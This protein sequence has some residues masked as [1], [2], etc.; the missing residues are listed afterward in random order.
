MTIV[1]FAEIASVLHQ[2]CNFSGEHIYTKTFSDDAYFVLYEQAA[3]LENLYLSNHYEGKLI[4]GYIFLQQLEVKNNIVAYDEDHSPF[5]LAMGNVKASHLVLAGNPFYINENL[6]CNALW[7]IYNHGAL[8]VKGSVTTQILYSDGFPFEFGQVAAIGIILGDERA[9][10]YHATGS[11]MVLLTKTHTPEQ[12]FNEAGQALC[13]QGLFLYLSA[14]TENKQP[15]FQTSINFYPSF[16][17]NLRPVFNEI[18]SNPVFKKQ[19]SVEIIS[20]H[21]EQFETVFSYVT[22]ENMDIILAA[23]THQKY[24]ASIL[25]EKNTNTVYLRLAMYT[26]SSLSNLQIYF[27]MNEQEQSFQATTVKHWFYQAMQAWRSTY[28]TQ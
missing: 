8:V 27:D 12:V 23:N 1:P 7:G 13:K 10:C 20:N 26:D 5:L 11:G 21:P 22:E 16:S 18:F 2:A 6:T 3:V 15:I 4:E 9:T 24:A 17:E 25:L 14:E 19:Q 28:T